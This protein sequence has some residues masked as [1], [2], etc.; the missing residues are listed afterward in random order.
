MIV[1]IVSML[2]S[3][4]YYGLLNRENLPQSFFEIIKDD[5]DDFDFETVIKSI[6]ETFFEKR[7]VDGNE[8][9]QCNLKFV[10]LVGGFKAKAIQIH[11]IM[12]VLLD[13]GKKIGGCFKSL[14]IYGMADEVITPVMSQ[15]L[16]NDWFAQNDSI[17]ISHPKRHILPT[18]EGFDKDGLRQFIVSNL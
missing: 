9:V 12:K 4:E 2:I 14:H 7:I 15:S 10:I 3:L 8:I 5:E 18:G 1:S 13:N 16:A 17:Q 6:R 11:Q